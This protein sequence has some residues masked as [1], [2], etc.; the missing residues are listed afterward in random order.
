MFANKT[1]LALLNQIIWPEILA[2]AKVEI[3]RYREEGFEN[4][5]LD[6]A[7]LLEAGWDSETDEVWVTIVPES[8]ALSRILLRDGLPQEQA[9]NR[10]KSQISNKE[11]VD[12]A[13][14]AIPVPC[15]SRNS[16]RS[17]S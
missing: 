12:K 2:Q 14:V 7:V 9:A 1:K 16:H 6:A 10:I 13:N 8:E 15:G 17:K 5:V 4:C 3:V 11:R